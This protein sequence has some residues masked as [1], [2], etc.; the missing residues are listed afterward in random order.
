M[1]PRTLPTPTI[2][3]TTWQ[4]PSGSVVELLE[5]AAQHGWTHW[6]Y[7]DGQEWSAIADD[8]PA[9]LRLAEDEY[10]P[11]RDWSVVQNDGG[12][13]VLEAWASHN[14]TL[15]VQVAGAAWRVEMEGR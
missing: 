5:S 12:R 8:L 2:P 14:Q 13:L 1:M 15:E 9:M 3:D 11:Q 7:R 6:R 10:L 4:P